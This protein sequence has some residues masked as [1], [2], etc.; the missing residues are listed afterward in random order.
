MK[1]YKQ[2]KLL[3]LSLVILGIL[4]GCGSSPEKTKT[5]E[6]NNS[7]QEK[8]EEISYQGRIY[9]CRFLEKDKLF[10]LTLDSNDSD[11]YIYVDVNNNIIENPS[12]TSD[13]LQTENITDDSRVVGANICDLEGND[14]SSRFINDSD[15]E[16][17]MGIKTISDGTDIVVVKE[18]QE[19][20][21]DS[22]CAIKIYDE[23]GNK[24]CQTDSN[25][26]NNY[27]GSGYTPFKALERLEHVEWVG[28]SVIQFLDPNKA[29]VFSI[30]VETGELL[31]PNAI[32]S[33]GY[34]IAKKDSK[35]VIDV[36]G[37]T[38]TDLS[39]YSRFEST[40]PISNNLFF[41]PKEKCFYNK[42]LEKCIDLS[43]YASFSYTRDELSDEASK[44]APSTPFVFKDGYCQLDVYNDEDTEFYGIIDS[45]GN[46][47]YPFSEESI[48][49][50]GVIGD[51][52]L[53]LNE[54]D[55][56]DIQS[57]S[58]IQGPDD[59]KS[60]IFYE[61]KAYYVNKNN[62]FCTYDYKT[63]KR[64]EL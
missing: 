39:D 61:G 23:K 62:C 4:S 8:N 17:I 47:I 60:P 21:S 13:Y 48:S 51:G 1:K 7:E 36:H 15:H 5:K 11:N 55:V 46:E 2:L 14:V 64:T 44:T 24:I 45:A 59:I 35:C 52:L 32:F 56:Y 9:N 30:N 42:E 43:Q 19:T 29:A 49:Y 6:S 10:Q 22:Y 50:E 40:F 27:L 31:P 38:I 12:L 26:E 25:V 33:E 20:P 53:C 28:D 34:A 18:I 41:N 63:Q 3:T 57:Q 54:Y 16:E 58:L 37:N